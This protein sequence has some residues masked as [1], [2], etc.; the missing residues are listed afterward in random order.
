MC[1]L[2]R[3]FVVALCLGVCADAAWGQQPTRTFEPPAGLPPV[4]VPRGASMTAA[5]VELGGMLFFDKRLSR[6]GTISCATCHDPKKA[7]AEHRATSEGIKKQVGERNA[8]TVI[9]AAYLTSQFWDGRAKSLEEQAVGPIENLIEM[10][11]K[12]EVVVRELSA[13]PEYKKRFR[14]A[15]GG[16]V[17][18]ETIA[19]AIAAFE[20]TILSG[21]SPYDRY[22]AGDDK[23][24]SDAQKRGMD[25]FM[26][27]GQCANCHTPP[28]F[29]SG[30]F[31][32]AGVD[33]GKKKPDEGRRKVTG[34]DRDFGKF[35][36]PPL[37]EV[38]GTAPYFHD[39]SV[40]TLEEAVR[41]MAQGGRDNPRLSVMLRAVR[42][43][44]LTDRNIK[45][46]VEFLKALSGEYPVMEPPKLPQTQ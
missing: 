17:T 37:R 45:D 40:G 36:V 44:R 19:K 39:G 43:S 14:D 24:L 21:N 42:E 20:R 3:I 9:N 29:S 6:D 8:P 38:A 15:F 23:A 31:H 35:R 34:K 7:W 18:A 13:I 22:E 10:G 12:L 4:P 26:N 33:S 16:D 5:R 1:V 25:L 46:I 2:A 32:N 11:H 28:I 27:E 41:L 30:R